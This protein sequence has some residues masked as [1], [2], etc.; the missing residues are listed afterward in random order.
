[1]ED[2][3]EVPQRDESLP[4]TRRS[5][6]KG[7]RDGRSSQDKARSDSGYS[8]QALRTESE[9]SS[10]ILQRAEPARERP[11]NR[12][13][14]KS[15]REK[16]KNTKRSSRASTSRSSHTP[17]INIDDAR[18]RPDPSY[19]GLS[20][21]GT[22][23]VTQTTAPPRP[24]STVLP[25]SEKTRP[26]SY[27]YVPSA[28]YGSGRPPL[29][30]FAFTN[31]SP[32][33]PTSYPP[34]PPPDFMGG[35]ESPVSEQSYFPPAS[36]IIPT[37]PRPL[38]DRFQ[39]DPLPISSPTMGARQGPESYYDT[40][41]FEVTAP[42]PLGRRNSIQTRAPIAF[43]TK[44][45]DRRR[46]PPPP[47]DTGS[48]RQPITHQ[49]TNYPPRPMPGAYSFDFDDFDDD[50]NDD[51]PSMFD[52]DGPPSQYGERP[53]ARA[54]PRR[55]PTFDSIRPQSAAGR[56]QISG[57]RS[58][59]YYDEPSPYNESYQE[60]VRPQINSSRP[61]KYY[62][63]AP[64]LPDDYED[65]VRRA[66]GYFDETSGPTVDLTTEALK[67]VVA[68]SH[69]TRST[70]SRD[71]SEMKRSTTT[72]TSRSGSGHEE[73][74]TVKLKGMGTLKIAG[75]EIDY[76]DGTELKVSRRPSIRNGSERSVS[77]Y[78][79]AIDDGRSSRDSRPRS[80]I[81]PPSRRRRSS[82]APATVRYVE[83]RP[84]YPRKYVDYE[85]EKF[86]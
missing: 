20:A 5:K 64:S 53:P 77:N 51:E 62:N 50:D 58:K 7:A 29:S 37:R 30:R 69:S 15:S 12:D 9:S 10:P 54:L 11:K 65:K 67:R 18:A 14:E 48:Y 78:T 36:Q 73:D 84:R 86:F 31:Q 4:R 40:S 42:A 60:N 25:S 35:Y 61:K 3:D 34:L 76:K 28:Q 79:S 71:D 66:A 59:T 33:L 16:E 26:H 41:G 83:D 47:P 1:M 27:V 39:T 82:I 19:Y 49:A 6:H 43:S 2:E 57:R 56:P 52:I 55:N 17:K 46:M 24:R 75:A 22:P 21:G 44:D 74:V 45:E 32:I 81:R 72:R 13:R 85:R 70:R 80:T 23:F 38:A 63:K 68:S 8:S